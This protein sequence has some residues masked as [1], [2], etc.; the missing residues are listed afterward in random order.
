MLNYVLAFFKDY[1]NFPIQQ[2][3]SAEDRMDWIEYSID[4]TAL[5]G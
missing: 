1:G 2:C 4:H 3:L 5:Q